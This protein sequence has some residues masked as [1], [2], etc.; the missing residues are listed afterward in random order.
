MKS[1]SLPAFAW[2]VLLL[3]II[4]SA[5][6]CASADSRLEART[7]YLPAGSRVYVLAPPGAYLLNKE[8]GQL[9]QM[10]TGFAN[11]PA[12][13]TIEPDPDATADKR[14]PAPAPPEPEPTTQPR[15]P[16]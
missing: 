9:A 10:A 13:V 11:V 12:K 2:I 7:M 1:P 3:T 8:T 14:Q 4:M 5:L 16:V 15:M 6:G